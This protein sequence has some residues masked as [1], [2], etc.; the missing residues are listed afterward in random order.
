MIRDK[1]RNRSATVPETLIQQALNT[2]SLLSE[3]KTNKQT[4]INACMQIA[5]YPFSAKGFALL[6]HLLPETTV[7]TILLNF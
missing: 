1:D 2:S 4:K 5:F 3:I 7:P 6:V